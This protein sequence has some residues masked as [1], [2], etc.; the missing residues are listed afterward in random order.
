[1]ESNDFNFWL[2]LRINKYC[3]PSR[4]GIFYSWAVPNVSRSSMELL[5]WYSTPVLSN[6]LFKYICKTY[7][8]SWLTDPSFKV[9]VVTLVSGMSY[10]AGVRGRVLRGVSFIFSSACLKS[11]GSHERKHLWY[12]L[13]SDSMGIVWRFGNSLVMETNSMRVSS[14]Q[15]FQKTF[16]ASQSWRIR[17]II[18][19]RQLLDVT[20]LCTRPSRD[21]LC[22]NKLRLTIGLEVT[23]VC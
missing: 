13:L 21:V 3:W 16:D 12:C 8:M 1:M 5:S 22:C 2:I 7:S 9:L 20:D 4:Y 18:F 10:L 19:K 14:L 17:I 11:S 23:G 6:G 15:R